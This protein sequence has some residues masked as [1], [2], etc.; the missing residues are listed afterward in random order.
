MSSRSLCFL[1]WCLGLP[2]QRP[3]SGRAGDAAAEAAPGE[4]LDTW[5]VAEAG[6]VRSPLEMDALRLIGVDGCR[7]GWVVAVS[8]L[9]S[10]L[11]LSAPEFTVV[12]SFQELLDNLAGVR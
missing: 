2:R 7:S 3:F 10:D 11:S 4:R 12:R 9:A 8:D 1:A 5:T 6:G